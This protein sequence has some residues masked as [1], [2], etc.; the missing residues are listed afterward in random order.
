[1]DHRKLSE[2]LNSFPKDKKMDHNVKANIASALEAELLVDH[3]KTSLTEGIFKKSM[4][5]IASVAA[6]VLFS[7]ILLSNDL[8]LLNP[9]KDAPSSFTGSAA[10]ELTSV[11]VDLK[12]DKGGVGIMYGEKA[13]DIIYP[14]ALGYTFSIK[15][16]GKNTIGG[17]EE[18]NR[19]VFEYD[20]GIRI[21]I[22]PDDQLIQ[23]SEE[24]MGFNLFNESA[25]VEARLG[26]GSSG[27]PILEPGAS[28]EY[29]LDFTLG[30][31]EKNPEVRL[32]P[33]QDQMKE[34]LKHA[35]ESTLVLYSKDE[36]I[37]RYPL[38][39]LA[40]H[41]MTLE[42]NVS[43]LTDQ[44]FTEVGAAGIENRDK[45]DFRKFTFD[46]GMG[47]SDKLL[48]RTI[49]IPELN[50]WKTAINSL[51]QDRY[52]FGSDSNQTTTS[53]EPANRAIEFVFYAK[54]LSEKEIREA[55]NSIRVSASWQTAE[56][57]SVQKELIVGD[58]IEFE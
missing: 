14:V 13:G 55:F 8:N 10:L 45:A 31:L 19:E 44:E 46:F 53:E 57:V 52:W 3:K 43:E 2:E 38:S 23:V 1:M 41:E 6:M 21:E 56:G 30:A 40:A 49:D 36:E 28:G 54:G 7:V 18:P 37:G 34:L 25:R 20:D 39:Q 29:K 50:V 11:S 27:S 58:L 48:S 12:N 15:N 42:A 16:Y 35:L 47:S 33:S 24:V 4:I 5:G 26:Q 32:A 51:G 17:M 22:L 9:G